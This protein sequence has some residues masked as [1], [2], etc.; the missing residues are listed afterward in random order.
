MFSITQPT[1]SEQVAAPY[2][3]C[4]KLYDTL[5]F[6]CVVFMWVTLF[7][8]HQRHNDTYEHV[9]KYYDL[10]EIRDREK[11]YNMAKLRLPE[12][13]QAGKARRRWSLL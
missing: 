11:R 2:T 13:P 3:L 9:P 1:S 4:G 5:T 6:M 10:I 7:I 12:R 8:M